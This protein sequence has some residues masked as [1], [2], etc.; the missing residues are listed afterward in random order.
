MP[1]QLGLTAVAFVSA[2]NHPIL[3]RS[4]SSQIAAAPKAA[5][6]Y[7]GFL[8]SME[9]V[10]VYA[11]VTPV[12]VKI[13]IALTLSD[14]VVRDADMIS[15]RLHSV[16]HVVKVNPDFVV[17]D[18]QSLLQI[19][20]ALH[21]AYY[22]SVANPFLKLHAP[23]DTPNDYAALVLAGSGQWKSFRRR[24]DEVARAAGTLSVSNA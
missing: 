15:V 11:Y 1:P 10:A 4:L 23:L 22:R 12:K 6:S 24:V 13:I 20:K 2:Q 8:Y 14:A 9:D 19:F 21:L 17:I 18:I 3:I 16:F 5:E 7:L